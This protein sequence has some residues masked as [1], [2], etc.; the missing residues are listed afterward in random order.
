MCFSKSSLPRH[1]VCEM[2]SLSM[3][4]NSPETNNLRS[5][6]S[7]L[8]G[9]RDVN[10]LGDKT[11]GSG[12]YYR[13][14]LGVAPISLHAY[15]PECKISPL[16]A[17]RRARGRIERLPGDAPIVPLTGLGIPSPSKTAALGSLHRTASVPNPT[18]SGALRLASWQM[19]PV[20]PR[21]PQ[22]GTDPHFG[23]EF[24]QVPALSS[25]STGKLPRP[26]LPAVSA[27]GLRTRGLIFFW[28][29]AGLSTFSMVLSG[30]GTTKFVATF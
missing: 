28:S 20:I 16:L 25:S 3:M 2:S 30:A 8:I 12:P 13:S 5:R 29:H 18:A 14:T 9:S 17:C 6:S 23:A 10:T 19:P 21:P 7:Y 27:P 22:T 1:S 11:E 15:L 4:F 26:Q 24:P